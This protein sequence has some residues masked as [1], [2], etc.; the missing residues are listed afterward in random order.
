MGY[1]SIATARRPGKRDRM[2]PQHA[3]KSLSFSFNKRLQLAQQPQGRLPTLQRSFKSIPRPLTLPK[4][5]S[6][7]QKRSSIPADPNPFK[8][9]LDEGMS[10]DATVE[11]FELK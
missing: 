2:S 5:S 8:R 7:V 3:S 1:H 6:S 10:I 9:K 11:T 4:M